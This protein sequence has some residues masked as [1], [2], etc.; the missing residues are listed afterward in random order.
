MDQQENGKIPASGASCVFE[1]LPRPLLGSLLRFWKLKTQ[2]GRSGS[3]WLGRNANSPPSNIQ[4][5]FL[6]WSGK[7]SL[8]TSLLQ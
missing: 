5:K 8:W 4:Y 3:L 2:M 1:N 7:R 6:T